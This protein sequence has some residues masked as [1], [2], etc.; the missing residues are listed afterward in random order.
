MYFSVWEAG[1]SKSEVPT[2]LNSGEGLFSGSQPGT[3]PCP[4]KVERLRI[5]VGS[6]LEGLNSIHEGT[7]LMI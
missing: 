3:S 2:W 7:P 4:Q 1:E 6:Q 5:S